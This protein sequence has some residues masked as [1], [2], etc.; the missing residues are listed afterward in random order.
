MPSEG[1]LWRFTLPDRCQVITVG[2]TVNRDRL[3]TWSS[4]VLAQEPGALLRHEST[5]G[6]YAAPDTCAVRAGDLLTY[7]GGRLV[8]AFADVC[9]EAQISEGVAWPR[10]AL[11]PNGVAAWLPFLP[12]YWHPFLLQG[13]VSG[14]LTVAGETSVLTG[15]QVYAEKAWGR[16]YPARSW[17]GQAHGFA[18]TDL[19]VAYVATPLPGAG[20]AVLASCVAR[21]GERGG[22]HLPA[23][24]NYA[25]RHEH[26]HGWTMTLR[27]PRLR[28][29]LEGHAEE[30]ALPLPLPVPGRRAVVTAPQ[31]LRST[32][33]LHVRRGRHVLLDAET[34]L[35]GQESGTIG[36]TEDVLP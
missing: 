21:L 5:A 10:T 36:H 20:P 31:A 25:T 13:R 24:A 2:C 7:R 17:W 1:Y 33:H 27:G 11:P 16:G 14:Q 32:L 4:A 28:M 9:L 3:G 22:W 35:A 30:P 6:G 29:R 8:M 15:S 23:L 12:T 18:R 26:A 34:S 19:C